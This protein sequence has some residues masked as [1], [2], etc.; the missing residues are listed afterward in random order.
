MRDVAALLVG[1][2]YKTFHPAGAFDAIVIGS[3]I[4]GLGT[5]AVLAR[6]DGRR[7]LVLERH[8]TAGG[9]THVFHRPGFEWDVGLHYIGQVHVPGSPTA[10]MYDYISEARLAWSA[11]P[12]EYDRIDVAGSRFDY[13]AGRDRLRAR[14][15]QSF[16]REARAIDRYFAA[17]ARCMRVMPLS[18]A[19]QALPPPMAPTIGALLRAPFLRHARRTTRAVL[20][21]TGASRELSAVLAAQWGDYGLPPG[22]SSFAIHAV[23][24]SHYVD[25]AAYPAG[26]AGEIARSV[27]PTIERRGGAVVVGA[28]VDRVIVRNR[29]AVGVRMI[30]GREFLA[31]LVVSDAGAATT[32]DRLV[33]RSDAVAPLRDRLAA[34]PPS[35]A[36]LAL[37]VGVSAARLASA[38]PASNL[39][40]H[41]GID[42]D[43]NWQAFA[44]DLDA[45]FPLLFISCPSA[46]D[47]TFGLR[48]PGHET[49]EIVVPAPF[50]PFAAWAH[51]T[52][53]RRGADYAALKARLADRLLEALYRHVPQTAGTVETWE[54]STP[55]STRHF[56]NAPHGETY[57]LAHTPARFLSPDLTPST[58]IP[59]LFLTGQDVATSGVTGALAG[60][61]SCASAILHRNVFRLVMRPGRGAV[62][63]L[64]A[65]RR[66]AA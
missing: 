30:D 55:L 39:W 6:A 27:L 61:I 1:T 15:I 36:H 46:K 37:Y 8:A 59:N 54:L 20:E 43:R 26:G 33:D 9:F 24:A 60:A 5:A 2:P 21:Q 14:L 50:A 51:T 32:F 65:L 62:G 44:A 17:V 49:I 40:I 34:L 19:A 58:P 45:P 57:G 12:D 10:A 28:E 3:G 63:T 64:P 11:M 25:G 53:K 31:P 47:P 29:R 35:A 16:P 52:W 41:P 22:Q 7:V 38:L 4:G 56:A 18:F 66:P 23:V 48:H 13:V 42:F